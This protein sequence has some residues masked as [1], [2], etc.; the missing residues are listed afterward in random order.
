MARTGRQQI[1]AR[2]AAPTISEVLRAIQECGDDLVSIRDRGIVLQAA[3]RRTRALLQADMA[4]VSLNDLAAG[5]TYIHT[6]DGVRTEAYRTIRMPLGTGILGTA[7]AGRMTAY[8][9]DYTSD[10]DMIHVPE[11]DR[12]VELEGVRTVT[13]APLVIG[14]RVVGALLIAHRERTALPAR[15][16]FAIEQLAV[17]ASIVLDQVSRADE[18][19]RLRAQIGERGATSA[20]KQRELERMLDL[21]DRLMGGLVR[22]TDPGGVLEILADVLDRPI[23]LYGPDG[24]LL[25]GEAVLP[26]DS[27]RE[28]GW[29]VEG[30]ARAS[31]GAGEP[32][33]V[34]L[35]EESFTVMGVAAGEELLGTI[36]MRGAGRKEWGQLRRATGFVSAGILVERMLVESE[37]RAQSTLIEDVLT[38]DPAHRPA[39]L[40]QRLADHGIGRRTPVAALCVLVPPGAGQ[41]VPGAIRGALRGTRAIVSPHAGHV[42]ALIGDGDADRLARTVEEALSAAGS[43]A[44]VG[45]ALTTGPVPD[46]LPEVHDASLDVARAATAMGLGHG[47]YDVTALGVAGLLLSGTT[48]E[49]AQRVIDQFIGPVLAYDDRHGTQLTLTAWQYFEHLGRLE[50]TAA[51]LHI[52]QN[53]VKQRLDR[54]DRVLGESWRRGSASVDTQFA[55]RL[56]RV[57]DSL[58]ER[59]G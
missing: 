12:I 1:Q 30:A 22:A 50:P 58:R 45:L 23:G 21:D 5:E 25:H 26:A 36:L 35:G 52:H 51:A 11:I 32:A 59:L 16:R 6:T 17:Q 37:H 13:G 20:I 41:R 43:P 7:A 4:Y 3:V 47:V 48:P 54:L 56:W 49:V 19:T 33:L 18:V 42:C 44:V 8:T 39:G 57:R 28:Y 46:V 53:T 40:T 14:G 31:L 2:F 38:T 34:R 10:P 55:L 9:A 29:Q 15:G 24:G 27:D